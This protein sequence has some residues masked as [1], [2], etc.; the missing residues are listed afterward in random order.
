MSVDTLLI[1]YRVRADRIDEHLALLDAV[2]Q[3]LARVRPPGF[4][5]LTLRLDDGLS[6]V[7]VVMGPDLPRPLPSLESF[8]R[9]RA[10]LDE[11][12]E[13]RSTAEF[14]VRGSY[15]MGE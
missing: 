5:Y 2:H 15:G 3:E 4:R 10:E 9:F 6:F 12:C 11:R 7:D 13:Q 14:T 1:S 8:S